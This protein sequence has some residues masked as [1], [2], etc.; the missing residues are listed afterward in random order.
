MICAIL[1]RGRHSSLLGEWKAAAEA[2]VDLVEIRAD[3]LRREID[4]KRILANRYT[5]CIFTIRRAVDGGMWRQD[6]EKRLRLLREAIVAGV[7]Y[8]D[9]EM[10]IAS[11]VP[12][13]GRTKRIV[14]YHNFKRVPKELPTLIEQ[15]EEMNADIVKVAAMAHSLE[16]AAFVLSSAGK[17]KVPVIGL[18]MGDVGT[19]T[20]VLN[21]KFG[22]PLTYAGFNPDRTFAPG[23]P[24]FR[25]LKRDYFYDEIDADTEIYAVIGD[26]IGHSLSPAVHNAVLK[27][28][29]QN[30]VY[31]AI[32][33][34][35]DQLKGMFAALA[36]LNIK[37]LS[38]TIPHK[39]AVLSLL[40]EEDPTVKETQ[41]CNTVV[42]DE[43]GRRKGYNTDLPAAVE[44]L[45]AALGEKTGTLS[46]LDGKQ[47]LI[48]GAGGVARSL[49]FGL[50]KAGAGITITSRS[51]EKA[52]KLAQE[53]GCKAVNWAMRA[54]T[55]CDIL[56]N[57]TPVGMH[58]NV[59]ESPVPPAAFR[60]GQL[61]F[62]TVYHPE[63][64]LFLKLAGERG[65][66]TAS[67]V[68][69]FVRQAAIQARLFTGQEP[70]L[71]LIRKVVKR[72]FSPVQ[73]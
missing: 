58:P 19:F 63:Q 14:S 71:D 64:T 40:D 49:A 73:E 44:T 16:E 70:P 6:E 45:E 8:V 52:N 11:S 2:G 68:D 66:R 9:L 31:V 24:H 27:H 29:G 28:F 55:L 53:V 23:L 51:E 12:R 46:L 39:E 35:P 22:S 37:G 67:G 65:G 48:L 38:V 41:A 47:V 36:P 33:V 61:C 18:A 15:M 62:D 43:R 3:L 13:F 69:M 30:K 42:I 5:P 72:K 25:D 34:P 59:D 57:C 60:Q 17:A 7:D 20:R 26:P 32:K 4:M 10:D 21:R 54:S 1:G 56:V 50:Q